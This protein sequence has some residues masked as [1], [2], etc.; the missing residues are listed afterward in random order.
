MTKTEWPEEMCDWGDLRSWCLENYVMDDE[1]CDIFPAEELDDYVESDTQDYDGGWRSLR[2]YLTD[3]PTGWDWYKRNG[4][5]DYE[6]M[7]YEFDSWKERVYEYLCE[8]EDEWFDAEE[9]EEEEPEEESG[10]DGSADNMSAS[11][12]IR[13]FLAVQHEKEGEFEPLSVDGI[14][15]LTS[16]EI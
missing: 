2:D 1:F 11:N 10:G 14:F 3:I 16:M 5:F 15:G 13:V 6:G 9:E 8:E 12:Y 4:F 7:D